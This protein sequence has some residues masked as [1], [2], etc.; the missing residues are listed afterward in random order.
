MKGQEMSN[1]IARTPRFRRALALAA[2]AALA[3]VAALAAGC[4]S[5]SSS[6]SKPP[7]SSTHLEQTNLTVAS[8]PA[9]GAAGLYIA[10]NQGLFAKAGLHVKIEPIADPTAIVPDM[11]HGSVQVA[12]GQYVTYIAASAAGVVKMQILAAGYELGPHVQDIMVPANSSIKTPAGLKGATIA[13]NAPDS[14]T[15]DL[16]YTALARYGITPSEVHLAIIGFPGMPTALAAGHIS[17]M[18]EVEPYVTEASQKYGDLKLV[19]IDAGSVASFPIAGY[20]VLDSW[21]AQNPHTAAAFAQAIA[22]GNQLAA[23]D[24]GDL[25]QAMEKQLGLPAQVVG[26]MATGVFPASVNPAEIQRVADLMLQF[27]QLKTSFDV[28]TIIGS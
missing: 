9:E 10:L 22:E 24:P 26:A 28:K 16:L 17:A 6:S 11:L 21:A 5:G 20:G 3:V 13:V 8:V 2:A 25:R 15:T 19:D 4:S 27:G 12:S 7:A 14:V 18:Y 23:T 1:F